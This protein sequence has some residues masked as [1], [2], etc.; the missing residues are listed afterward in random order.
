MSNWRTKPTIALLLVTACMTP[1]EVEETAV[2]RASAPVVNPDTIRVG[3]EAEAVELACS[4][5][6]SLCIAKVRGLTWAVRPQ[7][8]ARISGY[9][10]GQVIRV[11]GLAAGR[12]W[13]IAMGQAGGDSTALEVIP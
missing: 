2:D 3:A 4:P 10:A 1:T 13:V 12:S 8:V 9:E 11:R 5:Q 7:T 6:L